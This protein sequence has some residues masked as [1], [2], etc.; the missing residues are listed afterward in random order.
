MTST[1]YTPGSIVG[2]TAIGDAS[3]SVVA[4]ILEFAAA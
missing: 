3:G 1:H 2:Y 4:A